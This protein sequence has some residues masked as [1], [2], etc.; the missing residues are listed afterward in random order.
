MCFG[1]YAVNSLATF[2][3]LIPEVPFETVGL[4]IH[5]WYSYKILL[6][7][8]MCPLPG[9]ANSTF[10][11]CDPW[12]TSPSKHTHSDSNAIRAFR[13]WHDIPWKTMFRGTAPIAS[14]CLIS[15][16]GVTCFWPGNFVSNQKSVDRN[17]IVSTGWHIYEIVDL[18]VTYYDLS[19]VSPFSL[20]LTTT[21]RQQVVEWWKL[22]SHQTAGMRAT[23]RC[24]CLGR[25]PCNI[26]TKLLFSNNGRNIEIQ[27]T[28][29]L[30][31]RCL[32]GSDLKKTIFVKYEKSTFYILSRPSS[33]KCEIGNTQ[34]MNVWSLWRC[35]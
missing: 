4:P 8:S 21:L 34:K 9:E 28:E 18:L 26:V 12:V 11:C 6:L 17:R 20:L 5:R 29:M 10:H 2:E 33:L 16:T 23:R 15:N 27:H 7:G 32:G 13:Q 22:V 24:N 35:H 3:I 30:M 19:F 31:I 14:R 1:F 25:I